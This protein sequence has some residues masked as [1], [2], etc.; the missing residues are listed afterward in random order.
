MAKKI[1]QVR[2]YGQ[3]DARNQP[4]GLRMNSL[5]NGSVFSGMYPIV[6]L[7][8]QSL[9]GIKFSLNHSDSPIILGYTGIY[10]LE[11]GELT[12]ITH[13]S[14]DAQSM[15][16]INASPE[17]FLIVYFIYEEEEGK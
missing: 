6:Q 14:F 12:Q 8:I 1:Y 2:Y 4:Q 17:S 7:G 15:N 13:L 10:D 3:N 5:V 11:L 16:L 9:P